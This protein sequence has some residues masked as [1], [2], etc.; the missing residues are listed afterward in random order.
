MKLCLILLGRTR[1]AEAETFVREKR[2]NVGK[3]KLDNAI[4]S[5]RAESLACDLDVRLLNAVMIIKAAVRRVSV[6]IGS[7][8]ERRTDDWARLA[9]SMNTCKINY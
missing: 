2:E 1:R 4:T 9:A 3:A 8:E 7:A 6:I 5:A